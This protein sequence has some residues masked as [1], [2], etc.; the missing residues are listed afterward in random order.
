MTEWAGLQ[1]SPREFKI[2]QTLLTEESGLFFDPERQSLLRS[3]LETRMAER[4]IGSVDEYYNFIKCDAEGRLEIKTLIDLVTIGETYFFRNQPQFEVL[5][6]HLLPAIV[7]E[8]P[9]NW[10]TIR[11]WSAACST[12]E[13]PYSLAMML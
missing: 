1:L 2:F 3:G 12:G 13:E 9:S 10:K 8:R 5:R 4:G 7:R 6:D 11:I